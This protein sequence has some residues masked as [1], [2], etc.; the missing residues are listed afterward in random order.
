MK[1]KQILEKPSVAL[2]ASSVELCEIKYAEIFH[3][4][5]RRLLHREPQ[6][7]HRDKIV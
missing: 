7:K 6:R 5:T 2:C 3:R 1:K 4:D